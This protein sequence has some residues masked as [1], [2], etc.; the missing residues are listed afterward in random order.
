[1]E[2]DK[3]TI[4]SPFGNFM[5]GENGLVYFH[6]TND[7]SIDKQTAEKLL[8]IISKLDDSGAAKV[9]VIQG[10]RVEYSFEAQRLLLTSSSLARIAYVIETASQYLTAELLQ[11]ISKTFRSHIRVE[12]FQQVKD[13]EDWLLGD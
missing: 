2:P 3:Q 7:L 4:S 9:V 8:E 11:N 5:R 10:R 1:M 12:V 6:K 13:A